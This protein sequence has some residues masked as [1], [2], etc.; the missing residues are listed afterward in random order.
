M[1]QSRHCEEVTNEVSYDRSNPEA[2]GAQRNNLVL[3]A[4]AVDIH[5]AALRH[6]GLLHSGFSFLKAS[7]RND[8]YLPHPIF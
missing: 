8:G 7:I 5:W 6:N 2:H 3:I 4:P 1:L